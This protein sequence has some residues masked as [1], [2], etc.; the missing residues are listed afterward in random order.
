MQVLL[1]QVDKFFET[2]VARVAREMAEIVK[3]C[4]ASQSDS[5]EFWQY[6]Q[7]RWGK[8]S[9]YRED[10][11]GHYKTQLK[12]CDDLLA[13]CVQAAWTEDFMQELLAFFDEG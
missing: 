1:E 7:E 10:V 5:N 8:G 4:L 13:E 12:D 3:D 6:A 9:G 11:L 2:L